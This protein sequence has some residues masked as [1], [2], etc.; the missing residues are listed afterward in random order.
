MTM[1]GRV[2]RNVSL[3]P[4]LSNWV[5]ELVSRGRFSTASE[6]VRAGLRL[7]QDGDDSDEEKKKRREQAP[8]VRS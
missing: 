1:A 5:D 3:S 6:V 7:L 2:C 8:A 4:E